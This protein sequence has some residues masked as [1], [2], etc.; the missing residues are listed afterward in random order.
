MKV[1]ITC[2]YTVE[3]SEANGKK[4]KAAR[5]KWNVLEPCGLRVSDGMLRLYCYGRIRFECPLKGG[6]NG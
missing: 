2:G 4:L 5:R 1:K 3:V 6:Q